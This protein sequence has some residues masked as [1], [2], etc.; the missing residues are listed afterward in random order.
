MVGRAL[1]V[2]SLTCTCACAGVRAGARCESRRARL[3]HRGELVVL[4][5]HN[6]LVRPGSEWTE[7]ETAPL[8]AAVAGLG[9]RYLDEYASCPQAYEVRLLRA[10]ALEKLSAR[11]H[12]AIGR[13]RLEQ[14][15]DEYRTV[16]ADPSAPGDQRREAAYWRMSSYSD[17]AC[18]WGPERWPPRAEVHGAIIAYL[19]YAAL[20]PGDEQTPYVLL[21]AGWLYRCHQRCDLAVPIYRRALALALVWGA[22]GHLSGLDQPN[23][24]IDGSLHFLGRCLE[25]LGRWDELRAL[26]GRILHD[27]AL[28]PYRADTRWIDRALRDR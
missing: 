17:G 12:T 22:I 9:R 15:R 19:D 18:S 10:Y 27:E 23:G 5:W 4:R 28:A 14:A 6:G 24:A 16:A 7:V 2:L 21:R 25:A 8:L 1:V 3:L 13:R 20:F 11:D 26:R